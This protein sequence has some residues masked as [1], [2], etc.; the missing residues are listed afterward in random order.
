MT[1]GNQ[2]GAF[3]VSHSEISPRIV[4]LF[5]EGYIFEGLDLLPYNY[6]NNMVASYP[7]FKDWFYGK[8]RPELGNSNSGRKLLLVFKSDKNI[9]VQNLMGFAILKKTCREKKICS[10][11]IAPRER[12]RGYAMELLQACLNYLDTKKPLMTIPS[13]I[14]EDFHGILDYYQFNLT[15]E[16]SSYYTEGEVEYVFN[17]YL[18]NKPI[19]ISSKLQ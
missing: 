8:I 13:K 5:F 12:S 4:Q 7:Y 10:F 11:W 16:L 15:Q 2:G 6:F 19:H 14:K 18:K 3:I 17:G 9:Q 1:T